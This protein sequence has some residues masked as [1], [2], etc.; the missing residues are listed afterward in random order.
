MSFINHT[1]VTDN[2]HLVPVIPSCLPCATVLCL[3]VHL[4]CFTGDAHSGP[5]NPQLQ[6]LN[7]FEKIL[8]PT[9]DIDG[10]QNENLLILN[11]KIQRGESLFVGTK[12]P[13]KNTIDPL[14]GYHVKDKKITPKMQVWF[15]AHPP[16]KAEK[17]N[18]QTYH[19]EFDTGY[20]LSDGD[21][22]S[23]GG[24]L[25][26]ITAKKQ[27]LN[28]QLNLIKTPVELSDISIYVVP[29]NTGTGHTRRMILFAITKNRKKLNRY[30]DVRGRNFNWSDWFQ[31]IK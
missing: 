22:V 1:K 3:V 4:F 15:A 8:N 21:F 28:H 12:G 5:E 23:Y 25:F 16:Q 2:S 6:Q 24:E 18:Q 7:S 31:T 13:D 19:I 9:D 17:P 30:L 20:H 27:D 29:I 26:S 10:R 11:W 14:V